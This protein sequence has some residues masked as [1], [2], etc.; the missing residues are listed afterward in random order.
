[1]RESMSKLQ[2]FISLQKEIEKEYSN[3]RLDGMEEHF[4][5]W[6]GENCNDVIHRAPD[7]SFGKTVSYLY[8]QLIDC[9][10]NNIKFVDKY[11]HLIN[12]THDFSTE[13]LNVVHAYRTL[14]Q[15]A[16][17]D[18]DYRK[19]KKICQRWTQGAIDKEKIS[20][21]EEWRI[22]EHHLLDA[23]ITYLELVI[24]IL[25]KI[26]IGREEIQEEWFRYQKQEVTLS[27]AK[28]ILD[29]IKV[30]YGYV[31][32]TEKAY[33]QCERELKNELRCLD[34]RSDEIDRLVYDCFY[35]VI[36]QTNFKR[37][38]LVYP[39]EIKEKYAII[40]KHQLDQIMKEVSS[41]CQ[42]EPECSREKVWELID[43]MV[44]ELNKR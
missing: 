23:G 35:Q 31:F 14:Y 30:D 33:S 4:Y 43:R 36:S 22:C 3:I 40:N 38:V 13:F 17:S 19:Y 28:Q 6:L 29:Q 39:N 15:H 12:E 44:R 26:S 25:K 9:K 18:K 10:P 11:A 21:D 16:L 2:S 32:D 24:F 20:N 41:F 42:K 7:A 5:I 34:W 37:K 27:C 8:K 1:M